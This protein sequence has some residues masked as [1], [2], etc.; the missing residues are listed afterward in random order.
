MHI[1]THRETEYSIKLNMCSP[2]TLKKWEF[3]FMERRLELSAEEGNLVTDFNYPKSFKMS[4][5]IIFVRDLRG[6][7]F[8]LK[9]VGA[10]ELSF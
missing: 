10:K 2:V 4:D 7:T 9:Y 6:V 8:K 5:Q 3:V 1:C